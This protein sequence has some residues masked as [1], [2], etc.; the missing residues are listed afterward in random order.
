MLV[1]M[2][3][4]IST[5][6]KKNSDDEDFAHLDVLFNLQNNFDVLTF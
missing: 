3:Y 4:M 1:I 6:K 5:A 2:L